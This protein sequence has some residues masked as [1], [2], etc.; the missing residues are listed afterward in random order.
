MYSI[1]GVN[2]S[3]DKDDNYSQ[4]T[5][6]LLTKTNWL[7]FTSLL[8]LK[9]SC[10]VVVYTARVAFGHYIAIKKNC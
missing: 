10:C 1:K 7:D 6:L 2:E 9:V 4:I 8:K 5:V 3:N